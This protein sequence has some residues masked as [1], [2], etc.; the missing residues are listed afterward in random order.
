MN[1]YNGHEYNIRDNKRYI[2]ISW[3]YELQIT[4]GLHVGQ[5]LN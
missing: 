4:C 1:E 5:I 2:I 3:I